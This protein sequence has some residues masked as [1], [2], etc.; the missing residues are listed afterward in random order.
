MRP[1]SYTLDSTGAIHIPEEGC[2]V[3][4]IQDEEIGQGALFS[5][6]PEWPDA[7]RELVGRTSAEKLVILSGLP[8]HEVLE[9]LGVFPFEAFVVGPRAALSLALGEF[10]IS[11]TSLEDASR[12]ER[13]EIGFFRPEARI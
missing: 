7:V 10:L 9:A 6:I 13:I 4:R 8:S 3:L 12:A 2:V 5:E 1:T 11:E